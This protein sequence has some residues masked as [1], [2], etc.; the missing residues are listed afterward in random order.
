MTDAEKK[1]YF[2]TIKEIKDIYKMIEAIDEN[3]K[4]HRYFTYEQA[5]AIDL[6]EF[7]SLVANPATV[8]EM[9]QDAN[10]NIHI[11]RANDKR[12][13][14]FWGPISQFSSALK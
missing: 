14:N 11:L 6:N 13:G 10:E 1:A 8:W 9:E 4:G 7:D 5:I 3:Y 12:V 2:E